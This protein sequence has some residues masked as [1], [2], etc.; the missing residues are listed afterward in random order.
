MDTGDKAFS[1][2]QTMAHK[3]LLIQQFMVPVGEPDPD[4]MTYEMGDHHPQP[5]ARYA[6]EPNPLVELRAE[7]ANRFKVLGLWDATHKDECL[8]AIS[9]VIGHHVEATNELS[10]EEARAVIAA[11]DDQIS[12]QTPTTTTTPTVVEESTS[13]DEAA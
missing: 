5:V 4:S 1:K 6:T 3:T 11:L 2:A 12:Q 13:V 9:E 7:L 8:T 10:A